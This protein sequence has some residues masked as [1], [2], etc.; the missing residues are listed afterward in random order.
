MFPSPSLLV[1][2]ACALLTL[3]LTPSAISAPPPAAAVSTAAAAP[4]CGGEAPLRPGGGR[5]ACTFTENFVGSS[6]DPDR[7]LAQRS[8]YSGM[9]SGN[10][11]C[12]VE[13]PQNIAVA[14]GR[15]RLTSR[16]ESEPFTCHSPGGDFTTD[17]TAATVATRDRFTQAYGRFEIRARFPST[18]APGLHSALWL[19]PNR[20]YYGAWPTSGEIDIAEWFSSNPD[21]VFPSVHYN[22]ENWWTSTGWNCGMPTADTAFHRYAVEWTPTLMRFLQ[23]GVECYRH[24][25]T[26]ASPLVAPQPFDRPFYVV[27][28]QVYGGE[29][30]A[31]TAETPRSATLLVDWVRVWK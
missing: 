30:N 22:G 5:Y 9:T 27:L 26:P 4:T 24:S 19:Y 10:H 17:S 3:A 29:S 25:W 13:S 21:H 28:T 14:D 7:W 18:T 16:F 20:D 1:A 23:D 8:S 15:L 2:S 12:F 11:D 6:V 31:V